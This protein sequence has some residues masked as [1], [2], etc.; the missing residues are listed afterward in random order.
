M[1]LHTMCATSG[2]ETSLSPRSGARYP[3]T[4]YSTRLTPWASIF[5]PSGLENVESPEPGSA[6]PPR[7]NAVRG[8]HKKNEPLAAR[9]TGGSGRSGGPETRGSLIG[10]GRAQPLRGTVLLELEPQRH[11]H[12][13]RIQRR[14]VPAQRVT[15]LDQ[16]AVLPVVPI[17]VGSEVPTTGRTASWSRPVTL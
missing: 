7:S 9:A 12:L 3:Y 15:G 10:A 8:P 4:R 2:A 1:A 6:R 13:P 5:R 16:D 17:V 14:G 11:R